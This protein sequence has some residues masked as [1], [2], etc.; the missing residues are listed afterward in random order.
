MKKFKQSLNGNL[1]RYIKNNIFPLYKKHDKGH[2]IDHLNEVISRS[3]EFAKNYPVDLDMVYTI[4][5]YH[6]VG[7]SKGRENHEQESSKFLK[8]D[9]NLLRWFSN[10]DIKIMADAVEDHRASKGIV[11]RTIY[12][13]IV[14]DADRII[15]PYRTIERT[16]GYGLSEFP[17][18]SKEW[19]LKRSYDYLQ[20]KYGKT[21]YIKGYLPESDTT[22]NL[23]E[24]QKI[25]S[26]RKKFEKIFNDIWNK[27]KS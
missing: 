9:K 15:D 22:K 8:N 10:D 5:S 23:I 17:K 18:E 4:A 7:L 16:I 14:S 26:D 27:I 11:P 25:L 13:K 20:G 21:G 1:V 24:F 19:H 3:L 2:D 12:G 6:D